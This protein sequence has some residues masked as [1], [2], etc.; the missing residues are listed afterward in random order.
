MKSAFLP[1]LLGIATLSLL[2]SCG[3]S[4]SVLK[5][6]LTE[7]DGKFDGVTVEVTTYSRELAEQVVLGSGVVEDGSLVVPVAFDDEVPRHGYLYFSNPADPDFMSSGRGLIVERGAQ[8]TVEILDEAGTRLRILSDGKY[9]HLFVLPLEDELK[10]LELSGEL[11]RL[12]QQSAENGGDRFFPPDEDDSSEG[13][14]REPSVHAQVLDWESMNCADY[15]GEFEHFWDR[16]MNLAPRREESEAV[17]EVR[18]QLD[19]LYER[20]YNQ[21][22]RTKLDSSSDPIERLLIVERFFSLEDDERIQI[23]E[24]LSTELPAHVVEDRVEPPLTF[25]HEQRESRLANEALKLGTVLPTIDVKLKDQ[26]IVSLS[27]ILE[28]KQIVVL[29]LWDNY[30]RPCIRGFERYRSFYS[31]YA[32]LGFEVVSLS[33]EQNSEDWEEKSEELDLPWINAL[34]PGGFQGDISKKFGI[35]FPRANFVLDSEGCILKRNLTPDELRDFL[36][37]RLDS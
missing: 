28:G 14:I 19:E 18:K 21:R 17:I 30:C 9:A 29:D 7:F 8:Y 37:A 33:F 11:Q 4:K 5:G 2:T 12:F 15:A 13:T 10:E 32:D 26:S 3:S 1:V 22:L 24:E 16:R 31:D 36:G 23:L 25:L 6:D 20:L 27:S 35:G 34:A